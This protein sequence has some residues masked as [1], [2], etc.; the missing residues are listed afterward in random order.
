MNTKKGIVTI[1]LAAV[2][3]VS[4][5]GMA[6]AVPPATS[7][8]QWDLD[9]DTVMYKDLSHVEYGN[10]TIGATSSVVWRA[11]ESAQCNVYFPNET[12]DGGLTNATDL[13]SYTVDVGYSDSDGTN[14][15]SNGVPGGPL[16]YSG[17][18]AYFTIV[19]NGFTVP[20]GKYL[21]LNVTNTGGS[22]CN[23]TTTNAAS[24]LHWKNPDPKYPVP[25]LSTIILTSAGLLALVGYVGLRRRKN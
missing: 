16:G 12:W 11:D 10:V 7:A 24:W 19:A 18:V 5:T 15:T 23:I 4:M 22:D 21:A 14:F 25:E 2:F 9:N 13:P 20:L 6:S 3:L 1:V 8:M 17:G